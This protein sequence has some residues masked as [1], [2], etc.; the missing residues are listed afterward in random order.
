MK[1][2][3]KKFAFT[4]AEI[5][6]VVGIIGIIA[7]STIPVLMTSFKKQETVSRLEKT[8]TLLSQAVKQS[9]ID[10]GNNAQWDWGTSGD[11]ASLRTSFDTL[12]APYLRISKYC[13]TYQTCGYNSQY[14]TY[15]NNTQAGRIASNNTRTTVM[16]QDGTLFMVYNGGASSLLLLAD[17]NGYKPPNTVG[18]DVFYFVLDQN[19]G[20][21]PY[22]YNLSQNTRDTNGTG[23]TTSGTGGYCAMEI[24]EDGWQ[25]TSSY[26]WN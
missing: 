1:N 13:D 22:G 5:L 11:M 18:K 8:F 26:P 21:V 7:E 14:F 25:I 3:I 6:I 19:K 17:I 12:W 16:L 4:L 9:E 23:C 24:M 15:L 20:L 10:N 2:K